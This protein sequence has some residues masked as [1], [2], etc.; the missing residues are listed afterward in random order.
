[1]TRLARR[2]EVVARHPSR[3]C[4]ATCFLFSMYIY[5]FFIIYIFIYVFI[6]LRANKYY[7]IWQILSYVKKLSARKA[8]SRTRGSVPAL[9]VS[10]GAMIPSGNVLASSFQHS[11]HSR[12]C[13]LSHGNAVVSALQN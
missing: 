12:L 8:C 3:E 13:T 4:P 6:D 1:M 9:D 11:V 7:G 5:H 10:T 2:C